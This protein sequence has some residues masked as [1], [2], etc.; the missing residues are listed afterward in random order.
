M[1]FETTPESGAH[2]RLSDPESASKY[3][4]GSSAGSRARSAM[5]WPR[6]P[7]AGGMTERLQD[8]RDDVD[9]RGRGVDDA[10]R[11]QRRIVDNERHPERR[12]VR[13]DA[14]RGFTVVPEGFAV[15]RRED[16][17][18]VGGRARVENGLQER[19]ERRIGRGD[20]TRI[21]ITRKSRRKWLWRGVRIVRLVKMD[22]AKP[23]FSLRPLFGEPARCGG[24]GLDPRAF[25]FQKR[26]ASRR[27]NERIV[28]H[29]KTS[30]QA[31]PR[32]ERER[33][34]EGA[35]VKAHAPSGAWRAWL[36]RRPAGSRHCRGRH[37]RAAAGRS[38]Y[39]RARA[40]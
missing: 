39:W 35:G 27:V 9:V 30:G 20:F 13:K 24:N 34:D 26:R 19:A 22:P 29:V 32:V 7:A 10:R 38:G 37:D 31:K 21:G 12:L 16:N 17:Q 11:E 8:D 23:R 40:A 33:A 2:P 1:P 14:V 18:R 5:V 4:T 15:I 25:L 6:R 3:M 36:R 28:V